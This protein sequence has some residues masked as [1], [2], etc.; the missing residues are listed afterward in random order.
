MM[1]K[2]HL[3]FVFKRLIMIEA[4]VIAG[5]AIVCLAMGW[6]SVNE[7]AMAY[8]VVGV[9]IF[10]IGPFSMMGGWGTTRDFTY[11]YG[12]S[13]DERSHLERLHQ[14]QDEIGRSIGLVIPSVILG[15]ITMVLSVA[16]QTIFS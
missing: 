13:M 9:I 5:V 3:R 10:A 4:A 16:F 15:T 11:L 2:E 8:L 7:I 1:S 12:R 14:D 6:H